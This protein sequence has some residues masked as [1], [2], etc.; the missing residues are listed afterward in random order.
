MSAEENIRAGLLAPEAALE[1]ADGRPVRLS[2][3]WGD[4]PLVLVFMRHL[5]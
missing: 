5:G 4:G 3:L 2:D 1:D